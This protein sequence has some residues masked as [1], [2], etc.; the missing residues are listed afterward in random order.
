[1]EAKLKNDALFMKRST[2]NHF[3]LFQVYVL[4]QLSP[5]RRCA[6]DTL[7]SGF[8]KGEGEIG[9]NIRKRY[10]KTIIHTNANV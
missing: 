1:M 7:A 6:L 4:P 2:L 9:F 5:E 3:D 10:T 8:C